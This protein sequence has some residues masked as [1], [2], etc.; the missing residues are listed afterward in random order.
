METP[1]RTL[2]MSKANGRIETIKQHEKMEKI[3]G[4]G[5]KREE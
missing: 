5:G 4:G 1:T 3:C 2:T